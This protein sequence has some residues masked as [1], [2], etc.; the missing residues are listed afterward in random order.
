MLSRSVEEFLRKQQVP[1][2]PPSTECRSELS[3]RCSI[4]GWPERNP[5]RKEKRRCTLKTDISVPPLYVL[6][7]L[8]AIGLSSKVDIGESETETILLIIYF[9]T[10]CE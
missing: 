4:Q 7:I 2:V 9:Q 1:I 3:T 5:R 6:L 10:Q 8:E